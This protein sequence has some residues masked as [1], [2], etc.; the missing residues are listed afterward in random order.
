[1]HLHWTRILAIFFEFLGVQHLT[2]HIVSNPAW[3]WKPAPGLEC[4]HLSANCILFCTAGCIWILLA[5]G[6]HCSYSKMMA[7]RCSKHAKTAQEKHG[8]T[9]WMDLERHGMT[10]APGSSRTATKGEVSTALSKAKREI[11]P[12]P[13]QDRGTSASW[14]FNSFSDVFWP[15]LGAQLRPDMLTLFVLTFG[16]NHAPGSQ[17]ICLIASQ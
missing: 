4:R 15:F 14:T 3:P 16:H 8:R 7:A 17:R 5:H 2:D 10:W 9:K 13:P 6:W 11:S 12:L 1:M